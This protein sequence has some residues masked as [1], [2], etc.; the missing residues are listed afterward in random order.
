[1]RVI[2]KTV[3]TFDE[4]SDEAKERARGWYRASFEYPW[5]GEIQDSMNAFCDKFGVKILNYS[6][7]DHRGS[8]DTDVMPSHFRGLKLKNIN[9]DEMMTGYCADCDLMYTFYD[10]FKRTGDAYVAFERALAALVIFTARDI[11]YMLDDEHVDE[12]IEANGYEFDE[13]GGQA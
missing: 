7:G 4:L 11:E 8:I 13:F 9:R 2:E 3:Y 10:E 6:L 12:S 1:M 5:F